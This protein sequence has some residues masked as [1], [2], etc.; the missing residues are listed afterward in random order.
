MAMKFVDE[1]RIEVQAGRGGD[2]CASFRR[3]KFIP[4]GGPDGGDGG[5]GG[6]IWAVAD[7]NINTLTEY[8][9]R[10]MIAAGNGEHGRGADC[11]GAAGKDVEMRLPVGTVIFDEQSGRPLA[12]LAID[13]ARALLAK[14]GAGGLGNLHFKSSTNRAPRQKTPGLPGEHLFLRLELKV[15]ADVG[16][17]GLPNAGK[18][19]LIAAVSNARPK[20]ADY[21]FTTLHPHLGVV[22]L[23]AERS[24]VIADVPGLIE[25]AAEGAGLGHRFLRHLSRTKLLLHVIDVAPLDPAAD[26]IRQARA[27]VAELKKFDLALWRKPR[28]FV[29]NKVDLIGAESRRQL[30]DEFRR[31]LRTRAPFFFVSAVTGEGCRELMSAIHPHLREH[32]RPATA[33]VDTDRS[34]AEVAVDVS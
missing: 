28:W 21:P 20:I 22:R 26:P 17:F 6:S 30:A 9:Y 27:L 5:R 32:G 19:T 18:S 13:G 24:F 31:R 25:G 12:D 3:E 16:L 11:Y 15:L 34:L 33:T 7:N 23:D 10:R 8:R 1:A 29:F 14:G 2:G 4:K